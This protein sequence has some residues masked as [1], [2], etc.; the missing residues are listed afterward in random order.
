MINV[1]VSESIDNTGRFE[2]GNSNGAGYFVPQD[3]ST[4]IRLFLKKLGVNPVVMNK[5]RREIV[6]YQMKYAKLYGIEPRV[7]MFQ[8]CDFHLDT[9]FTSYDP[10]RGQMLKTFVYLFGAGIRNVGARIAIDFELSDNRLSTVHGESISQQVKLVEGGI[11]VLGFLGSAGLFTDFQ[12]STGI[13]DMTDVSVRMAAAAGAYR[14]MTRL[15]DVTNCDK[16]MKGIFQPF[17]KSADGPL[18]TRYLNWPKGP[19][20][21]QDKPVQQQRMEVTPQDTGVAKEAL[22]TA[23]RAEEKAD[24]ALGKV[25]ALE[26]RVNK[27]RPVHITQI[28]RS[29]PQSIRVIIPYIHDPQN[30]TQSHLDEAKAKAVEMILQGTDGKQLYRVDH[31]TGISPIN[32]PEGEKGEVR[33][34]AARIGGKRFNINETSVGED[35]QITKQLKLAPESVPNAIVLDLVPASK[36][37]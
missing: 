31:I 28:R 3:V 20:I 16:H 19:L 30:P 26:S 35:E 15:F 21:S 25:D 27:I 12:F 22:Q 5:Q 9:K 29:L 8:N 36:P 6:E 14:V 10:I 1:C 2:N 13:R 37:K 32:R 11:E 17:L 23:K 34:N 7:G 33:A 24:T 4:P 18:V